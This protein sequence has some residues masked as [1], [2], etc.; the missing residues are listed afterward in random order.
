MRKYVLAL[1]AAV[2]VL[3]SATLSGDAVMTKDGKTT[4]VNTTTLAKDTKGYKGIVPVKLYIKSGKIQKV[5]PLANHE[6][7]RYFAK[8]K[9]IIAKFEGKSVSSA[10]SMQV[11]G[12]TGATF[13]TKALVKNIQ[14]GAKYYK[15]HK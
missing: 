1:A 3:T 2:V 15:A 9:T 14:E 12:T 11:D 8:A 6:T 7:P 5:E 4:I 13:S 10:A